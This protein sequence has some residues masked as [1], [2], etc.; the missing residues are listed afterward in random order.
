MSKKPSKQPD[1]VLG[2]LPAEIIRTTIGI[3]LDPGSVI[4]SAA[5]QRHAAV[6]HPDEYGVCLPLLATVV[7]DPLYVGDDFRNEGK[8]EIIGGALPPDA[9]LLIAICIE[10][11]TGG[12]Y[13]VASFYPVS[14]KKAQ[15]RKDK[16]FLKIALKR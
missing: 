13:H 7:A 3:D 1:L 12:R 4:V 8:I 9:L 6:R 2:P 10:A 16:G 15:H 14:R 5:A 11:D